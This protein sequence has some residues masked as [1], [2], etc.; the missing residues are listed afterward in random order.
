[1]DKKESFSRWGIIFAGLGMAVG[2]GNLW[3]FPRI[4]SQYGGGAFMIAWLIFLVIW[5][6]PL[7][8]I[9]LSLGKK[10]RVGVIGTF[11]KMVGKIN[12]SCQGQI[13]DVTAM[14]Q[15]FADLINGGKACM[16]T[17]CSTSYIVTMSW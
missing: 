14:G 5:A 11:G 10:T 1:M 9:E 6:F 7:L 3:R 13:R 17:H 2:T 8:T 12:D 4:A 15:L 16:V